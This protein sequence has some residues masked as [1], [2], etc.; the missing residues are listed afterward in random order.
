[1]N[2][3]NNKIIKRD[4]FPQGGLTKG[5]AK[6]AIKR[7]VCSEARRY[8]PK[9]VKLERF[10]NDTHANMCL[11][12]QGYRVINTHTYERNFSGLSNSLGFLKLQIVDA[13][14]VTITGEYEEVILKVNQVRQN[15]DEKRLLMYTFQARWWGAIVNNTP[16]QNNP[17][18][19]FGL[20]L[21]KED[22]Y[23]TVISFKLHG[24]AA[25]FYI[26]T[27]MDEDT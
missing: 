27:S 9:D 25:G 8:R 19:I 21:Y 3:T 26:R 11:I 16:I 17:S 1:M 10:D 7:D 18:L 12:G 5:Q 15:P 13:V 24:L 6:K 4:K 23:D 20:V 2:Q 22:T 14:T